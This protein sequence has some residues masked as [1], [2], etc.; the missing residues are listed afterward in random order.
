MATTIWV[1]ETAVEPLFVWTA[2]D[3]T[4]CEKHSGPSDWTYDRL[5]VDENR[6]WRAFIA[7]QYGPDADPCEMCRAGA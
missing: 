1:P 7:E 4:V 2:N 5:T 3:M 6:E